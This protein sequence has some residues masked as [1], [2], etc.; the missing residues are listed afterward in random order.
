MKAYIGLLI[1]SVML[2]AC[3]RS[4]DIAVVQDLD[5]QFIDAW[6]TKNADKLVGYLAE[7]VQFVQGNTHFSGKSDV[8]KK[9]VQA[10][11]PTLAD[12][13]TNV[14]SSGSDSKTAYEAGTFSVDVLPDEPTLPRGYGEGN[15]I[16]LWK[17]GDDGLWKLSY[18]QLEDLPVRAKN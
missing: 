9:W 1:A 16:L 4:N 2:G 17:K 12:L 10:T 5:R 15:F 8:S 13:K 3:S 18:A 6:N 7:D 14:V 11:L